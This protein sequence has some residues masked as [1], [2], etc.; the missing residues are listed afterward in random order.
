MRIR[1]LLA[2]VVLAL[3]MPACADLSGLADDLRN[4]C[5]ADGCVTQKT[6]AEAR[7]SEFFWQ[8]AGFQPADIL[9]PDV[10]NQPTLT[11]ILHVGDIKPLRVSARRTGTA[12]DCASKA[13]SVEWTISNPDVLELQPTSDRLISALAALQ[14]GDSAVS[15]NLTFGDGSPAIRIF[16][17]SFTNVGSGDITVIRVLP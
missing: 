8:L 4:P 17:W 1:N 11:A 3:W 5:G 12:E 16:P 15:A 13:V 7:A 2:M 9:N 14:P 6:C 10:R